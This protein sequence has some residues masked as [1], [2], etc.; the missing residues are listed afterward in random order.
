[1]MLDNYETSTQTAERLGIHPS[2]IRRYCE[3]DRIKGA[4]K[5]ANRWFIPTGAMPEIKDFGRPPTWKEK[6]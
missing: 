1:M 3:E 6:A 4:V 5:M 2:Q